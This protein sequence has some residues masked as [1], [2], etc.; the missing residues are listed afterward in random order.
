M[1]EG[2]QLVAEDM[3]KAMKKLDEIKSIMNTF[4]KIGLDRFTYIVPVEIS[5]DVRQLLDQHGINWKLAGSDGESQDITVFI[6][7][8]YRKK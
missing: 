3:N 4:G 1:Y 7:E 5:R 8:R 2:T 6:P